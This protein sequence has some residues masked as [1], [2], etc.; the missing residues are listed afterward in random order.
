MLEALVVIKD[1]RPTRS[2]EAVEGVEDTL[3]KANLAFLGTIVE[4]IVGK[5]L[6]E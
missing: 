6:G 2:Q 3:R 5:F 1:G 4:I